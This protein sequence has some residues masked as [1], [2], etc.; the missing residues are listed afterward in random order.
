MTTFKDRVLKIVKQ[1]PRGETLSYKQVA[2]LAGSPGASRVVGNIMKG[3]HNSSIPCHRVIRSDGGIG[4]YNKGIERK[5]QL[6]EQEA[7]T[8]IA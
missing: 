7:K 4:E 3:N 2:Q 8:S 1:I 6:L 5:R